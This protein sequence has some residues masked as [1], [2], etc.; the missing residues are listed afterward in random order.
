MDKNKQ[1]IVRF[2]TYEQDDSTGAIIRSIDIEEVNSDFDTIGHLIMFYKSKN[3][4]IIVLNQ[5]D[6]ISF[7]Y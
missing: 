6:V 5:K 1:P 7:E 2:F 4:E 3:D